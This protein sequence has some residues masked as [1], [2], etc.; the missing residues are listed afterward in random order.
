MCIVI[1]RK[2]DSTMYYRVVKETYKK[3]FE[4]MTNQYGHTV[5]YVI[6]NLYPLYRKLPFFKRIKRRFIRFLSK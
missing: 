1:W 6:P 2:G 5:L 4:G 3:Y